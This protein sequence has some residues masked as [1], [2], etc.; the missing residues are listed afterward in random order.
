MAYSCIN[1]VVVQNTVQLSLEE[2]SNYCQQ[3]KESVF[4]ATEFCTETDTNSEVISVRI[5]HVGFTRQNA[6]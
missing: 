3:Q 4:S 2:G 1:T 5:I 6:K